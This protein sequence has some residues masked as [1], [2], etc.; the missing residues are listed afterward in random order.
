[1]PD[2]ARE[3]LQHLVDA[4]AAIDR[5]DSDVVSPPYEEWVLAYVKEAGGVRAIL[6]HLGQPPA[7]ARRAAARQ[8]PRAAWC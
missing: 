1:M 4:R 6:E 7:G 2:K 3:V 8:P 5:H